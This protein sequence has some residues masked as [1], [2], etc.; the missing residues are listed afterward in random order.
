[1]YY[2]EF[3]FD[4]KDYNNNS[5][6]AWTDNAGHC[7]HLQKGYQNIVVMLDGEEGLRSFVAPNHTIYAG[8]YTNTKEGIT[9][10]YIEVQRPNITWPGFSKVF[11]IPAT[12]DWKKC[13]PGWIV[14]YF[15]Q[16]V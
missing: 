4:E 2:K 15:Q 12:E 5:C 1:M 9:R 11:D 10:I 14:K 8:R 16:G 6:T 13:L 3:R 7:N